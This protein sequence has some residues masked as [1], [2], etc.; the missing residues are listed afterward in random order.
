MKYQILKN[1]DTRDFHSR[2]QDEFGFLHVLCDHHVS[3]EAAKSACRGRTR[4]PARADTTTSTGKLEWTSRADGVWEG[5]V[6]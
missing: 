1:S 2:T 3:L 6:C 4:M 5:K